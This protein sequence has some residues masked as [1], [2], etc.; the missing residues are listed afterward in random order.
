MTLTQLY[1]IVQSRAKENARGSYV[2]SLFFSGRDRIIQKMGEE[3]SEV[4][5]AAK[6]TDRKRQ[7][8]EVCDLLFHILVL[9]VSLDIP[10]S[11]IWKELERRNNR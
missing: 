4:L 11:A 1:T 2:A 9:L 10:L 6:N 5:I 8:E 7:V 3:A